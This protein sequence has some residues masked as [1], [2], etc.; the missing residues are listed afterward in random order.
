L[1][2]RLGGQSLVRRKS[3][4]QKKGETR[5]I[6]L[7]E[8][9]GGKVEKRTRSEA[10]KREGTLGENYRGNLGPNRSLP[11]SA[12]K[13]AQG[14]QRFKSETVLLHTQP[15]EGILKG[16][17]ISQKGIGTW[18]GK[19]KIPRLNKSVESLARGASGGGGVV[20]HS[21]SCLVGVESNL[22]VRRSEGV[23]QGSGGVQNPNKGSQGTPV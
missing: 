18:D 15:I 12:G 1:E 2:G 11:L 17:K 9:Q 21:F 5:K 23:K 4:E 13:R 16:S 22:I 6:A 3:R 19:R 7:I 10:Y 14:E 20:I 8:D